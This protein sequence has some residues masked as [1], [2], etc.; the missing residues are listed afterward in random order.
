MESKAEQKKNRGNEEFKKSNF[1]AAISCY[2]D[3]IEIEPHEM[4]FSNR[5]MALIKMSK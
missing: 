3:A 2:T 4:L 1:S 5:A